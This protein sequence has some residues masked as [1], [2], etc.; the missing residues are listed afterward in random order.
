MVIA[1]PFLAVM[2]AGMIDHR[3]EREYRFMV[4]VGGVLIGHQGSVWPM[5]WRLFLS[6]CCSWLTIGTSWP[7]FHTIR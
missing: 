7:Q 1:F 4:E 5:V 2:S 6:G 3:S